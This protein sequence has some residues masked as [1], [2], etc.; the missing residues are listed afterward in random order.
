TID[1]DLSDPGW[2]GATKVD[3]WYETNPGDNVPP[4]V[5]NTAWLT[6]DE[7]YLYAGF[8][9]E[10]PHPEQIR[11]PFGDRDNVNGF[12]DYGGIIIDPR[13]D[14]RTALLLLTNAHGIQYDAVS[15]DTTGN[16]D[17][18]PDFFWDSVARIT[19]KGWTLEMRVP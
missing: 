2:Q 19:S 15:D 5:K 9:F 13:H 14:G 7:K 1:G 4:P 18:S 3:T 11:A 17:N 6:Y 10:D 16:E 12:T 8:E